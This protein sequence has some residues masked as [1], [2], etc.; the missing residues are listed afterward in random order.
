MRVVVLMKPIHD[1]LVPLTTEELGQPDFGEVEA[2]A[3]FG[4]YDENA[5]E[6]ALQ[7]KDSRP[8]TTVTV[9]TF[10]RDEAQEGLLRTALAAGADDVLWIKGNSWPLGALAVARVLAGATRQLGD[11]GVIVAGIQS[12]DWDSGLVPG[13][14]AAQLGLP[15]IPGLVDCNSEAGSFVVSSQTAEGL[16][17]YEVEGPWVASVT[18][19]GHNSL[20]YPTVKDRFAAKRKL[21][22]SLDLPDVGDGVPFTLALIPET[23]RETT[24][25]EAPSGEEQGRKLLTMLKD[26]RWI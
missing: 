26:R 1:P 7:I 5:L 19:A 25:V 21:I 4:P 11:V 20:R 2:H 22:Q 17:T 10:F 23:P 24:Y 13:A 9:L 14:V 16:S 8:D 18:S 12:G 6:T 15:F 3:T